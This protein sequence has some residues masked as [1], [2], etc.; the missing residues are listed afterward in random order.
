[1]VEQLSFPITEPKA[2][3]DVLS[4]GHGH[5]LAEIVRRTGYGQRE[6]MHILAKMALDDR[7]ECYAGFVYRLKG[8]SNA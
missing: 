2:I 8:A 3:L 6:A 7:V 4:D 1:M 5:R